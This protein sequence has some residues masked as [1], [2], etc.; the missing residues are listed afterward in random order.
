MLAIVQPSADLCSLNNLSH[1]TALSSEKIITG[2]VSPTPKNAYLSPLG[3]GAKLG[4]GISL[5][6]DLSASLSLGNSSKLGCY[7]FITNPC[8]LSITLT[9]LG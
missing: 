5:E 8:D 9:A 1:C 2:K 3:S 6:Y 4:V 7:D